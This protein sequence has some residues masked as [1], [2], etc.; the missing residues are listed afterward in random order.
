M[1]TNLLPPALW[2]SLHFEWLWVYH[3]LVPVTERWSDEI[4]VPAGWFWVESGL[5]KIRA[6]GREIIVKPGQSFFTAP[7]TR[8]QWFAKGTKLLSVGYRCQW[9]G[10]AS[11][12]KTGLNV[13]LSKAKSAPLY[14]AANLLFRTVHGPKKEVTY[15]EAILSRPMTLR[16]WSLGE[17]GFRMW[18][19]KYV[20]TLEKMGVEAQQAGKKDRTLS[21][22]LKKLEAWPLDQPLKLGQ[23]TSD[24]RLSGRRLHDLLRDHLGMTAQAWLERRRLDNARQRL[25]SEDTALKEIAFGLGFRHPPHFTAWFKRHAGMTPTAFRAGQGVEGA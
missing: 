7:G 21:S 9:P 8:R 5:A 11:V 2:Q 20:S 6:D 14:E 24:H 12:F 25:A 18:F 23:L 3:G 1:T 13:M 4:T 17:A 19:E 16:Q 10:G 22:L 15:P